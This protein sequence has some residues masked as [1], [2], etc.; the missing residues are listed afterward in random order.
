[1]KSRLKLVLGTTATLLALGVT[2]IISTQDTQAK[3]IVVTQGDTIWNYSQQ[4]GVD[5]N[6]IESL[7]NVNTTNHVIQVGDVINIP[8]NLIN[9]GNSTKIESQ[10][11]PEVQQSVSTPAPAQTPVQQTTPVAQQPVQQVATTSS[12]KEWI[13]N[14]ESG[15][16]YSAR[17]GQFIGRYQLSSSYLNGDYSEANQ[18]RVANSYVSERYGSW[19]NAKNFWLSNGWY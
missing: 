8:D 15:G 18:E 13:A 14:K 5:I 11:T 17:N 19:D 16:S 6:V 1:M 9:S 2:S 4:T 12:A 3:S 10:P 7:N